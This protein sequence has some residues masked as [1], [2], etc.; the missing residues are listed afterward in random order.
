MVLIPIKE[1]W[2]ETP[3]MITSEKVYDSVKKVAKASLYKAQEGVNTRGANGI[4]YVK[5][6]EDHK[7]YIIL[8][9]KVEVGKKEYKQIIEPVEKYLIYPLL[10]GRDVSKWYAKPIEYLLV[11]HDPKT[12]K[13]FKKHSLKLEFPKAYSYFMAFE[14]ELEA[15]KHYARSIKGEFPFYTLFQ[16]N[17]STFAPYKVVWKYV[18]G[19]ISGKGEFSSVV[20]GPTEDNWLGG[21]VVIPNEK[22]IIVPFDNEDEAHYVCA[23]LNSS[24]AQ[25]IVMSYT[26]ETQISTHVLKHVHVPRF[27]PT[28]PVHIQLSDL[29]KRAHE[30]AKAGK[31]EEL[32]EVEREIN[33][34]VARLYG[35]SNKG[36]K[37]IEKTITIFREGEIEE[38]E[39]EEEEIALPPEKE[40]DIK[41]D[42]LLIAEDRTQEMTLTISNNME[43]NLSKVGVKVS[44]DDKVL[45]SEEI[46]RIKSKSSDSIAF[47]SPKLKSGEYELRIALDMAGEKVE[48]KRKLFV[49]TKKK[50]KKIK[51]SR[52]KG[53]EEM[54]EG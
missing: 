54:L 12:G 33:Q 2:A 27:G 39:E 11:P 51:P 7:E 23:V 48:E 41:V 36:L 28:N 18:A 20:M 30:L 32:N 37:E 22:C 25:L 46:K 14:K 43:R 8:Q 5:L 3:W 31:D 47:E 38:D 6:L 53:I 50:E 10:R 17:K 21:K 40:I 42:P 44:L 15:R 35:I 4:F 26:I 16:V 13:I 52:I 9:N 29:S 24:V 1:G 19:K 49:E 34:I 45:C